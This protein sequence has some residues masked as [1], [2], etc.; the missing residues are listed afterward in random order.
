MRRGAR[1]DPHVQS[2]IEDLAVAGWNAS[3][4]RSKLLRDGVVTEAEVPHVRTIR[5][6]VKRHLAATPTPA[7][8]REPGA[9]EQ[10]WYLHMTEEMGADEAALVMGVLAQLRAASLTTQRAGGI[11]PR[12][13]F[14]WHRP[15][16]GYGPSLDQARWIV[17][18]KRI[19][20]DMPAKDAMAWAFRFARSSAEEQ[21]SLEGELTTW[22]AERMVDHDET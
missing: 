11:G 4:I 20:P 22:M 21:A 19:A 9:D 18:M 13:R 1:I 7:E 6:H 5:G 10:L 8:Q 15:G 3:Q 17:R 14:G 16:A 2:A 12:P